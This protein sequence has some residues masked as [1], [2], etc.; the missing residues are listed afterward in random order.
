M[1]DTCVRQPLFFHERPATHTYAHTHTHIRA[2]TSTC[3]LPSAETTVQ[4]RA[5]R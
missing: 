1:D 3:S 2:R 4:S 5:A